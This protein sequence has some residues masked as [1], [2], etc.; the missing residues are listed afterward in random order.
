MGRVV[1]RVCGTQVAGVELG[2]LGSNT[3]RDRSGVGLNPLSPRVQTATVTRRRGDTPPPPPAPLPVLPRR[4][5]L[6]WPIS[7]GHHRGDT[8]RAGDRWR[9]D[10]PLA[11]KP[12]PVWAPYK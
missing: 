8:P 10:F 3:A 5:D 9:E 6:P 1:W 2:D 7:R 4:D 11:Y 12:P